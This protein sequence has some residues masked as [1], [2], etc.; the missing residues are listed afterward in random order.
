[1]LRSLA[2]NLTSAG[3]GN[4]FN[5]F[6]SKSKVNETKTKAQY[7]SGK[8]QNRIIVKSKFFVRSENHDFSS[9]KGSGLGIFILKDRL[10]FTK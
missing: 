3:N 8:N 5:E 9:I 7:T 6:N 4:I 2:K 10:A 1:M